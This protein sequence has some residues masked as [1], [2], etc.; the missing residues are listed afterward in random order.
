MR[1]FIFTIKY[2]FMQAEKIYL[3]ELIEKI[4]NFADNEP[5]SMKTFSVKPDFTKEELINAMIRVGFELTHID[6]V[7][8]HTTQTNMWEMEFKLNEHKYCL[9]TTFII[10]TDGSTTDYNITC[11]YR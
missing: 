7:I 4:K 1:L 5:P 10:I 8:R 3:M 6:Y 9:I 2:N 11:Y